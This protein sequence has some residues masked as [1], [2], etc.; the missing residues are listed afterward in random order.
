MNIHWS[1]K[2]TIIYLKKNKNLL[3]ALCQYKIHLYW[4]I[5]KSSSNKCYLTECQVTNKFIHVEKLF[6]SACFV[7][8]HGQ[9]EKYIY[10]QNKICIHKCGLL[11][12]ETIIYIIPATKVYAAT[13][14]KICNMFLQGIL[15]NDK[16]F[17]AK[18][19]NCI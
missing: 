19:G 18:S 11:C 8:N 2:G 6:F 17:H 14:H 9:H 3:A 10:T 7:L 1:K 15:L 4:K 12:R 5:Y 16:N 13:N